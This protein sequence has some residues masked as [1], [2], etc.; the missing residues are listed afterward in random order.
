M[1]Y[2]RTVF[3]LWIKKE[4]EEYNGLVWFMYCRPIDY[5]SQCI[6]L[7]LAHLKFYKYFLE[8]KKKLECS[9]FQVPLNLLGMAFQFTFNLMYL[10]SG[11]SSVYVE[12]DA[13]YTLFLQLVQLLYMYT[14][15]YELNSTTVQLYNVHL[16][17]FRT[18]YCKKLQ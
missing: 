6:F 11:R 17:K 8:V 13:L 1:S 15:P 4:R 7:V 3:Q 14:Q 2:E 16:Q 9:N 12:S 18:S 10:S 5:K